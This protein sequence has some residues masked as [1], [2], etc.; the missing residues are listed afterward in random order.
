MRRLFC[1]VVLMSVLIVGT[2][3]GAAASEALA[4]DAGVDL[5]SRYVWRGV[6]IGNSPSIQPALSAT[7]HG[8]QLGAWGAYSVSSESS[9]NDE[10]DFWLSYTRQFE[11]DAAI[12]LVV[13]DYCFPNSN[14]KFSS[15]D[16]HTLET[17]VSITGPKGF[18]LVMAGY[19]NVSNDDGNNTYFQLDYPASVGD[20]DL[21]FSFGV[22]GGSD[23]NPDYYGTGNTNVV[24]VGISASRDIEVTDRFSVPLTG[25]LI[26]N[27]RAELA[28]L[29]VGLSF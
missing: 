22:A 1:L 4:V 21:R 28:Y 24:N 26:Y 10:I 6:D 12:A 3:V 25:S 17:G 23:Q 14:V 9:V 27:P 20:V 18:P 2:D 7:L 15:S 29:V 16:A 11:N 19:V 8:V 5:Y 13:T